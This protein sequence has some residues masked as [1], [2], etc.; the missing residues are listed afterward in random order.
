[1]KYLYHARLYA[2]ALAIPLCQAAL[3]WHSFRYSSLEQQSKDLISKQEDW[4][5]SNQ[6][7]IA[8]IAVL[9]SPERI[10][11]IATEQLGLKKVEPQDILQ[12]H[13]QPLKVQ[14]APVQTAAGKVGGGNG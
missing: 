10:E 3:V 6:R 12:I 5:E 8:S 4:I 2:L 7:L 1:M 11:Q 14:P 13:I 9:S